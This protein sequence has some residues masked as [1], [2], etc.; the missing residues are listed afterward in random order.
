MVSITVTTATLG[1]EPSRCPSGPRT[2]ATA[3]PF[4]RAP[5]GAD[6]HRTGRPAPDGP[7]VRSALERRLE[8]EPQR[9]VRA[10]V[11]VR[12]DAQDLV[13]LDPVELEAEPGSGHV[14]PPDPR[15]AL[16]DLGHRLVPVG[17]E[18]AAP[19]RERLGV[20]LAEVLLVA[21]L[22]AGVVHLRHQVTGPLQLAVG[23]DVAVDEPVPLH[24]R[25]RVV[26]PGDAVVQQ[27]PA[28]PQLAV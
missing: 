7:Y 2:P 22:E 8:V 12:S 11:L 3:V 13:E 20:V 27:P 19:A 5:R 18:V 15:R 9:H 25:T 28:G 6:G 26:G 21:D 17:V 23:E 14:E 4:A 10:P 16:A 24:R 1:P